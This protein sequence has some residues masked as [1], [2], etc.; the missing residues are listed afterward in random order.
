MKTHMALYIFENLIH[1][2]LVKC[3]FFPLHVHNKTIF[4]ITA[5]N[6]LESLANY[7]VHCLFTSKYAQIFPHILT[8]H[9]PN[10]FHTNWAFKRKIKYFSQ[11]LPETNFMNTN[12][13]SSAKTVYKCIGNIASAQD[14]DDYATYQ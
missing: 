9:K 8:F 11:Q 1:N 13:H 10:N 14:M 12:F 2:S 6:L 7:R 3:I 5:N 4:K